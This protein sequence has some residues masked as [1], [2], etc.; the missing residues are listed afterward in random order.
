MKRGLRTGEVKVLITLRVMSAAA[1]AMSA[2]LMA[3]CGQYEP[4][5]TAAPPASP[6]PVAT[7]PPAAVA[8]TA[9]KTVK[10]A[11]VG[12]GEKG[13]DY[14]LGPVSTPVASLWAVKEK[15]ALGLIEKAMNEFRAVEGRTPKSHE[16]FMEKII[17]AN[18]IRLPTLPP[19]HRYKY[20]PAQAQLMVEQ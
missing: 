12:M 16:E 5:K 15:L 14:P 17:K 20:D 6:Q 19:G 1:L 18:D 10:P 7:Q 9:E 4:A 2:A 8:A 3:G 13:R 11:A